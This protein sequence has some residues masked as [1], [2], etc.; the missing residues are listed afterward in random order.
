MIKICFPVW[1]G[2]PQIHSL[3]ALR[4]STQEADGA[5]NGRYRASR[6]FKLNPIATMARTI[7]QKRLAP[8]PTAPPVRQRGPLKDGLRR[9]WE[10][11]KPLFG[12]PYKNVCPQSYPR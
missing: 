8:G 3:C 7:G 6:Y 5:L 12:T 4:G 2:W 11:S 1:R 9:F 10:G